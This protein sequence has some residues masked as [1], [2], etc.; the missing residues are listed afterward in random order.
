MAALHWKGKN[1]LLAGPSISRD[2]AHSQPR[3][4]R[5]VLQRR[6]ASDRQ[7]LMNEFMP[8]YPVFG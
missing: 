5:D 2:P 7:Q 4:R 1:G 8:N 6:A 3:T